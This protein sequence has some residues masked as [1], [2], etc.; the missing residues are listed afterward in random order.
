MLSIC[1]GRMDSEKCQVPV[2]MLRQSKA[3]CPSVDLSRCALL[4]HPRSSYRAQF[5]LK[6]FSQGWVGLQEGGSIRV[7][8]NCWLCRNFFSGPTS[9]ISDLLNLNLLSTLFVVTTGTGYRYIQPIQLLSILRIH[10]QEGG[11]LR[12]SMSFGHFHGQTLGTSSHDQVG[13]SILRGPGRLG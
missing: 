8:A 12:S 7:H 5:E 6:H 10:S 2:L 13:F 1:S 4:R 11:D 3:K 9:R